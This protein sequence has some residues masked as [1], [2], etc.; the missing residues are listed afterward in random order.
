MTRQKHLVHFPPSRW[1]SLGISVL[2]L[3]LTACA[4]G[5]DYQRPAIDVGDTYKEMDRAQPMDGAQMNSGWVR[6]QPAD[7]LMPGNWWTLFND[8]VLSGLMAT[9]QTANL[10]IAQAEAQYRQAQALLQSTRSGL[11]PTL[12]SSAS[13]TRSGSG[14]GTAGGGDFGDGSFSPGSRVGNQYSVSGNVS[15]EPDVWGRVRRSVEASQ[16]GLEASAADVA[17]TRLSMQSTL[18][19]TYF[20]LRVMDAEQRLLAQTVQAYERS[21]QMT[22]N[23]YEA[24]VAAQADVEVSRTQLENTRTQLLALDWQRAQL[25]HAI[26][27]LTGQAPSS[28]TLD[29]TTRAAAVPTIPVALP[30]QLLQRRP[31]VA[32]AERR[33]AEANARIGVAQAAWFPD[34]TLS[35]Q[36]G[37]RSGQWAQWLTAPA[38]FWSLGPA[39]ALTIFDGGAREA[40]LQEA[41]AGYDAQAAAYRQTVLTALREVEDY[42]V[43][44]HVLGQEQVTQGRALAA[45]RASLRLTQNQ[46]EAGLIDYLS[47]VQVETTALSTERAA[48]SL[49]ADRLV[50]SVQLIAALGG[51]WQQPVPESAAQP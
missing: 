15:W 6:A 19:Q 14:G 5:P 31:D 46:F 23:R 1:R 21:L 13:A 3:M 32:A 27:V 12:G 30:S 36:A 34:L 11:F 25:E 44:L 49:T 9:L 33:T 29:S 37:F 26:A 20:R 51:G 22:Q 18:A 42:L 38:S 40:Q 7:S 39:L 10:D 4:V 47:V 35:A 45:A 43:Q 50:A 17:A 16:A 8:P 28:F 24:G 41:R 2:A 48:L